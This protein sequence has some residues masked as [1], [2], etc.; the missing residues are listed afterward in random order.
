MYATA[1]VTAGESTGEEK[2]EQVSAHSNNAG[3]CPPITMKTV[4]NVQLIW[5]DNNNN[6]DEKNEDSRH[7]VSQLRCIINTINKFTD[8]DECIQFINTIT[9]NKACLIISGSLGQHIV[10]RVHS[11][12]QVDSIFILCAIKQHHEQW[13]REWPKIKGVFTEIAPICEALQQASKQC[14]HNAISISFLSTDGDTANKNVDRLDPM[15][16][17]TQIMKEV[18]LTID[19]QPQHFKE[20]IQ[21]CREQFAGNDREMKM[22]KKF[23]RK[24]RPET[25]IWWYT[26]QCF[27]FPML[28]RALRTT[29]VDII[30]KIGFF[31]D[32]LHRQIELLHKEQ[33]SGDQTDKTFIVH[34][35]QGVSKT[36]FDQ[37]INKKGTLMSFNNFLSTSKNRSVSLGFASAALANPDS[38]AIIFVMTIDPS[39]ST[40]P[41]ASIDSV[42]YYRSEDEVLFSMNTVFRIQDNIP[43]GETHRLFQVNLKLTGD[44][45]KD[46]RRLTDYIRRETFSDLG[47][48]YRLGCVLSKMGQ[49]NKAQQVYHV[50]LDQATN[51]T[52]KATIYHQ[53]GLVI[54][55]QG[56][57]KEA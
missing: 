24:Y 31:I 18:L 25:S 55:S 36:D 45:D 13:A 57:Y 12:S 32:D 20:F 6:I 19:F 39:T 40:T 1:S 53:L 33:F 30:I 8:G 5:L 34:R 17:Y 28:N 29:D 10:P 42:S 7:T 23:D 48:W 41:F 44:N 2:T 50:L 43:L 52:E 21:Y 4:Q 46:L 11:M 16:M 22:I 51:D 35:G 9:N 3:V 56:R 47:S 38:M 37:L 14:E 49:F 27:L 54:D 26:R 15:F